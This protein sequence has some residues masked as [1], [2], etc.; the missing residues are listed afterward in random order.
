MVFVLKG[1]NQC[2]QSGEC[3]DLY[4]TEKPAAHKVI[5]GNKSQLTTRRAPRLLVLNGSSAL[6]LVVTLNGSLH[7]SE[8][9][10]RIFNRNASNLKRCQ[11]PSWA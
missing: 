10:R 7:L 4:V 1:K 11:A 3:R 5:F 8:P 2:A 6:S 9:L